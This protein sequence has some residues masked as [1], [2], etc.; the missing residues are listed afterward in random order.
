MILQIKLPH[1]FVLALM[2]LTLVAIIP[3]VTQAQDGSGSAGLVINPTSGPAG[4]TISFSFTVSSANAYIYRGEEFKIVWDIGGWHGDQPVDWNT[5]MNSAWNIIGTATFDNSGRLSGNVVI[6]VAANSS[7][8]GDHV[9]YAISPKTKEGTPLNFWWGWFDITSTIAIATPTPTPSPT[10]TPTQDTQPTQTTPSGNFTLTIISD[11]PVSVKINDQSIVNIYPY[12]LDLI[13]TIYIEG[14]QVKLFA[15]NYSGTDTLRIAGW[16]ISSSNDKYSEQSDT[17]IVTM[18]DNL[19][20]KVLFDSTFIP[21][22]PFESIFIGLLL[23]MGL[24]YL[25]KKKLALN[26][27]TPT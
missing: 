13:R 9:I 6:P 7:Q 5:V 16:E 10:P 24:L 26:P 22:F 19:T 2:F 4:T 23:A 15:F 8:I 11:E 1:F 3:T 17:V 14:T 21:G 20:A 25:T 18:N 27:S 12:D